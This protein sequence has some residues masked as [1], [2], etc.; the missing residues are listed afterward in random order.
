MRNGEKDITKINSNKQ[1]LTKTKEVH[2][3]T[4]QLEADILRNLGTIAKDESML[5]RAAKYLRR[6]AKEMTNKKQNN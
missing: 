6:L 5:A 3:N 1:R 2:M 4:V